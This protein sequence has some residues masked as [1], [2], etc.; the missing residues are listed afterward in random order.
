[1]QVKGVISAIAA[2]AVLSALAIAGSATGAVSTG[3]SAWEWGNPLPQGNDILAVE[4]AGNRGY[5]AGNFGTLLTS[6]DAGAGWAGVPTGITANL[7]RIR[8]IDADSLVIAGGCSVRRSDDSGESFTRLAWTAND[9]NCPS[10]I[11]S[12]SFPTDQ[13]GYL[14]AAD[15]SVFRTAD[16]GRTWARKTAV[17]G[18]SGHRRERL[19]LGH[20]VHRGRYRRCRHL[21]GHDLPHHRRRHLVDARQGARPG[22]ARPVLRRREHRLRGRRRVLGAQDDRRRGQL[23]GQVDR[24]EPCPDLDQMRRRNLVPHHDGYRRPPA[25]D[26]GRR[27]QLLLGHPLDGEDLR[28]ELRVPDEGDR[29]RQLRRDGRLG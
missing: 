22:A 17:P 18:N 21:R 20:L 3:H 28:R 7:T 11:T 29:G 25:A 16:G 4:F 27:G 12:L 13:A 15:G 5:A 23:D 8:I 19:A 10:T 24:R 2:A 6:T 14:L 1:M 26:R 9:S